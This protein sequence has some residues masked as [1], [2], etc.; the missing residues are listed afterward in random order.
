MY[1]LTEQQTSGTAADRGCFPVTQTS[2]HQR[3]AQLVCEGVVLLV[4]HLRELPRPIRNRPPFPSCSRAQWPTTE[5]RNILSMRTKSTEKKMFLGYIVNKL[6][7]S[8]LNITNDNTVSSVVPVWGQ[9]NIFE[10]ILKNLNQ[11]YT[12]W[13]KSYVR[14]PSLV[15]AL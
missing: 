6:Y 3:R 15:S 13:N 11:W 4:S 7:T 12:N 1:W 2:L 5:V 14:S 10:L 9:E 8:D